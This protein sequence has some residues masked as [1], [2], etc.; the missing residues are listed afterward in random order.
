M[1]VFVE[2]FL[3]DLERDDVVVGARGKQERPSFGEV[4]VDP[5]RRV[6][7]EVGARILEEWTAGTGNVHRL[8]IKHPRAQA[9]PR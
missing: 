4:R 7:E 8:Q 1:L 5:G 9:L 3:G 2:N 6:R